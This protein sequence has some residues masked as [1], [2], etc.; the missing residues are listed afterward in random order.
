MAAKGNQKGQAVL[1]V[2]FSIIFLFAC[3]GLTVD[4]GWAYY[5]RTRV[6]TAADA[7]A[8]SAAVWAM[9]HGDSCSTVTCNSTYTC[10][11]VTPPTNALQAGCLYATSDGPPSI[12]ATMIENDSS[13]S[14]GVTGNTP[15]MWV[16]ATATTTAA[17]LFLFGAGF[18][19]ATISAQ[20]TGSV[21]SIPPAACIY[22]LSSNASPALSVTGSSTVTASTCGVFINS[23]GAQALNVQG[24]S[25]LTAK[26]VKV[27]GTG[28]NTTGGSTVTPAATLNAGA[29]A[30]PLSGM[31]MPAVGTCDHTAYSIGNSNTATMGP[32]V[33]CGG[34]TVSGS[35]QLTL[36]QGTYILNGGGLRVSNSGRLTNTGSG[37]TF[38]NTGKNGYALGAVGI[39]GAAVLSVSAPTSGAYKGMLFLEDPT[40]ASG[41]SSS[42]ANSASSTMSGTFYFPKGALSYT[43]ASTTAVFQAFIVSTMTVTGSSAFK[44]DTLGTYTGLASNTSSLI[45]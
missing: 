44:N 32:G 42:F 36:T 9:N 34:I 23:N 28:V 13:T 43:G 35:A 10:A 5:L 1:M 37:V 20:S 45:Q 30:D 12:T 3:V 11:G 39:G 41:S 21:T 2:T 24:S 26:V 27:N 7:A 16:R 38:F 25:T 8:S 18:R 17:N 31:T 6:Q 19:S 40:L 33:Y 4:L 15:T 29:V 22:V 14:P